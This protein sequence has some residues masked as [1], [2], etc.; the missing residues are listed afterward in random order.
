M[1]GGGDAWSKDH[2]D[3]LDHAKGLGFSR[4][5]GI[6][7]PSAD[8]PKSEWT[9]WADKLNDWKKSELSKDTPIWATSP[10]DTSSGVTTGGTPD[11]T[12]DVIPDVKLPVD[13][14]NKDNPYHPMLIPEYNDPAAQDWSQYMPDGESGLLYQPWSKEYGE[15]FVPDNIWNYEPPT[16]QVGMPKYTKNPIGLLDIIF[17]PEESGDDDD[18]MTEQEKIESGLYDGNPDGGGIDGDG[19]YGPGGMYGSK[20]AD[21]AQGF[22]DGYGNLGNM[23]GMNDTV[24]T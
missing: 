2:Q 17:P 5:T 13:D 24:Y 22:N 12:P 18:E 14:P 20:P 10:G 7:Y 1:G 23:L 8:A 15:E 6:S 9:G 21:E 11:V 3:I 4:H 19:Q 16:F